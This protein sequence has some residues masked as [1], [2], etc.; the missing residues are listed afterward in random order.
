ETM[1][2]TPRQAA[3]LLLA[4]A[5]GAVVVLAALLDR[6][7]IAL[8]TL[9]IAGVLLF[10]GVLQARRPITELQAVNQALA[11]DLRATT[12]PVRALRREVAGA[13]T[14]HEQAAR[15]RHRELL[16][17]L[18]AEQQQASTAMRR[19]GT[20]LTRRQRDQTREVEALLQ[21]FRKVEP[22]AP[23][24]SSGHWALNPTE[25][26]ELWSVIERTRP[27]LVL[28]LGSGTS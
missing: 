25:L 23:M 18:R 20:S 21:L 13:A 2:L 12:A 5:L 28:E 8:A 3:G 9:G 17:A 24:P 14:R 26:L 22:V 19:L 6:T 7:A 4:A 11:R 15:A 10:L 16:A 1:S 27:R